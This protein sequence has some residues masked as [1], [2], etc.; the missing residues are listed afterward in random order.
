MKP[1]EKH[2]RI[3]AHGRSIGGTYKALAAGHSQ[4]LNTSAARDDSADQFNKQRGAAYLLDKV[5]TLQL[6]HLCLAPQH[7]HIHCCG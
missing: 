3:W 6:L 2:S 7:R 5:A 1:Q 4:G